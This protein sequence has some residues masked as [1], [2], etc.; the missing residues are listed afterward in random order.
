MRFMQR[1]TFQTMLDQQVEEKRGRLRHWGVKNYFP[2]YAGPAGAVRAW[3][4]QKRRGKEAGREGGR[5]E[6]T[7]R[8]GCAYFDPPVCVQSFAQ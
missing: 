5:Q 6:K 8:R 3:K 2:G 7:K 4:Q 1:L